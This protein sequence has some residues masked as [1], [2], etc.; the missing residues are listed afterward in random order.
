MQYFQFTAVNDQTG[1]KL[2]NAI[3]T[4]YVSGSTTTKPALFNAAGASISNPVTFNNLGQGGFAAA[5]QTVDIYI[6]SS[7]LS[8]TAPPLLNIQLSS[9]TSVVSFASTS[10]ITAAGAFDGQ[11]AMVGG[12]GGGLFTWSAASTAAD[13]R[14]TSYAVASQYIPVTATLGT[15]N[16]SQTVFSGTLAHPGLAMTPQA[17]FITAGGVV[18][19]HDGAGTL[20]DNTS[21]VAQFPTQGAV[22]PKFGYLNCYNGQW[23]YTFGAAPANGTAIVG[24]YSYA[25]PGRWLR[26]SVSKLNPMMGGAYGDCVRTPVAQIGTSAVVAN[27]GH[28]DTVPIQRIFNLCGLG[29]EADIT[30]FHR[31]QPQFYGYPALVQ[32]NSYTVVDGVGMGQAGIS[33]YA[34]GGLEPENNYQTCTA[35]GTTIVARFTGILI[36]GSGSSSSPQQ[37]VINRNY[38]ICSNQLW[39]ANAANPATPGANAFAWDPFAKGLC[40]NPDQYGTNYFNIN[41]EICSNKGECFYAGGGGYGLMTTKGCYLHDTNGD[42]HSASARVCFEDNTIAYFSAN[43]C[44]DLCGNPYPSSY[45]NNKSL[46]FPRVTPTGQKVQSGRCMNLNYNTTNNY[47]STAPIN[48]PSSNYEPVEVSGNRFMSCPYNG[49]TAGPRGFRIHDNAFQDCGWLD[50]GYSVQIFTFTIGD[51]AAT[52]MVDIWAYDNVCSSVN[53][54][55]QGACILNT[56]SGL[57][58]YGCKFERN[59]FIA[60]RVGDCNF[61]GSTSGAVLTVSAI[62]SYA[63]LIQVG[64]Y[65]KI[66]G[67]NYTILL[68]GTS[69]TTGTGGTGTYALSSAP[70]TTASTSMTGYFTMATTFTMGSQSL[71]G[72]TCRAYSNKGVGTATNYTTNMTFCAAHS[73]HVSPDQSK[74][75]YNQ[76]SRAMLRH[77]YDLRYL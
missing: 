13:D 18:V 64:M 8:Y 19:K 33:F 45:K 43:G 75:A 40:A 26:N 49:L 58:A 65:I 47:G 30:K 66:G 20:S 48:N 28:D 6:Q 59:D 34:Y 17:T 10:S 54:Q 3:V 9:P 14:I 5:D 41:M 71:W 37:N 11:V 69:G 76:C 35:Y 1:M 31:A 56:S 7:D 32:P 70:A 51:D 73:A 63:N 72:S 46:P 38:T 67:N 53:A 15:G 27:A 55:M 61:T 16:G 24:T 60:T 52:T 4:V 57:Q 44:E 42:C 23:A 77:V 22:L 2:P 25:P 62:S 74:S 21:T 29:V 39:T 12:V 50:L 68:F 36:L